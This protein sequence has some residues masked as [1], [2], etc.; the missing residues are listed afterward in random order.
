MSHCVHPGFQKLFGG[1][2][3]CLQSFR[4]GGA[5]RRKT[6]LASLDSFVRPPSLLGVIFFFLHV[7]FF[8]SLLSGL[9]SR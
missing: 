2:F 9:S 3:F 1:D 8:L 6:G 7:S 4:Q 5:S